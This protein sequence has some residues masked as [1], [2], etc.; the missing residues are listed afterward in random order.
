MA[1][2]ASRGG[3]VAM[4][5]REVAVLLAAGCAIG[6][7]VAAL[8]LTGLTSKMLFGVRPTDPGLF[9]TAAAVLGARRRW[10]RAGCRHGAR[11]RWIR[12]RLCDTSET[13]L[14]A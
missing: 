5:L 13:G 2:G 4:V 12:W 3:I 6:G 9:A 8:T 7:A 10:P 11:R 1:L 14:I